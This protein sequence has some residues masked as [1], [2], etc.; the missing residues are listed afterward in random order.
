MSDENIFDVAIIGAG[1]YVTSKQLSQQHKNVILIEKEPDILMVF[2]GTARVHNGYHYPR[3]FQQP[4][5]AGLTTGNFLRSLMIGGEC[6]QDIC[7][8]K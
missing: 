3:S 2:R 1:F 6:K 7:V 4:T 8:S 5:E